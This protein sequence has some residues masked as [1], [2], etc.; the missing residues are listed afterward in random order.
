MKTKCEGSRCEVVENKLWKRKENGLGKTSKP[1]GFLLKGKFKKETSFLK[2]KALKGEK[3]TLES[4]VLKR[5]KF[6]FEM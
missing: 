5:K 3:K 1:K 2:E 4:K 6:S